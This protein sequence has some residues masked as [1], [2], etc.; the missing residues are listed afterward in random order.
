LVFEILSKK[1]SVIF[2]GVI[3]TFLDNLKILRSYNSIGKSYP[4]NKNGPARI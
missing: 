4:N 1:E 2:G 3:F